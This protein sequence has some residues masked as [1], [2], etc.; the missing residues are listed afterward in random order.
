LGQWLR[1]VPAP[2]SG[3]AQPPLALL[4]DAVTNTAMF[5]A[6]LVLGEAVRSR[7]ALALEQERSPAASR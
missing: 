5:A 1:R 2:V 4:G 7:R 3:P 6:V